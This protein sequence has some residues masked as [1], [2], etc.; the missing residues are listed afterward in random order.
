MA[1]IRCPASGADTR[2][3]QS[4]ILCSL[5]VGLA[6]GFEG[7]RKT[8]WTGRAVHAYQSPAR[9]TLQFPD[10]TGSI[11]VSSWLV[12][13]LCPIRSACLKERLRRQ[14]RS[15]MAVGLRLRP[16]DAFASATSGAPTRTR[17]MNNSSV[18]S[19]EQSPADSEVR[20][21]SSSH[22]TFAL[23]PAR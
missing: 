17:S 18:L 15:I 10:L 16:W 4:A 13:K 6:T 8:W 21:R 1:D 22:M 12:K 7:A 5:R 9:H 23:A 20:V 3:G 14:R 2:G 11:V 19:V